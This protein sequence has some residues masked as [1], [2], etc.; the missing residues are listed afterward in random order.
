MF[1]KEKR[2]SFRKDVPKNKIVTPLFVL[3]HETS[4]T[5]LYAV[6]ASKTV[7]KKSVHRNKAKRVFI[8]AL[9]EV[10]SKGDNKHTL[11][12]FL[13][14]PF[15]EYQKSGIMIELENLITRIN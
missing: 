1:K 11:V 4:E 6:I 5:P 2:F 12:F 15:S 13:R 7:S 3:R 9:R 10:L 14:R 8:E